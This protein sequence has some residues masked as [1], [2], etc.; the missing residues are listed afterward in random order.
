MKT[1]TKKNDNFLSDLASISLD[2]LAAQAIYESFLH[3]GRSASYT[4]ATL[5]V[6]H[7]ELEQR[8]Q[9]TDEIAHT[10]QGAQSA[11]KVKR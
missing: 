2:P 7:G 10:K 3:W 9:E 4:F 5:R 8:R 6:A 11:A 1:K